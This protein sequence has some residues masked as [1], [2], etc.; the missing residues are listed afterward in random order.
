MAD[1]TFDVDTTNIK[2]IF[3]NLATKERDSIVRKALKAGALIEQ[4]AISERAPIKDSTGGTLPDGALASDI[5]IKMSRDTDDSLMAI[6]GPGKYTKHVARWVEYGHR[7]VTGGYS[8][9]LANGKT[10]GPGKVALKDVPEHPFLRPA[11]EASQQEVSDTVQ[12][13]LAEEIE[14]IAS[15]K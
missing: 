7:A 15:R 12:R 5:T 13:V 1:D 3:D 10:R 6:V 2:A 8:R 14:K 9:L 11:W 4:H